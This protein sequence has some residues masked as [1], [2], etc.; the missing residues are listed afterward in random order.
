M[1]SK[2]IFLNVIV[3]LWVTV[4]YVFFFFFWYRLNDAYGLII[5][6]FMSHETF[7]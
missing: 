7:H 4:E 5:S 3:L 1:L 2:K 6:V